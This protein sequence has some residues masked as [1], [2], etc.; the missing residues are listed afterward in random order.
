LSEIDYG[1]GVIDALIIDQI[2]ILQ[3]T[4]Q[5]MIA[6]ISLLAQKPDYILVDGN[7]MPP[8]HISG[9]AIVKG[10]SLS[11]SI[12]AASIIAKEVRDQLMTTYHKE[13]PEYGFDVHKGYGTV[14]HRRALQKHGPCAIHR[15][16]FEPLKSLK[17]HA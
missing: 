4:F 17:R 13:W 15:M 8:T 12:A 3:A 14:L 10:D 5:A 1:V 6:A 7:K 11:Q 9:E 16:S 2:N